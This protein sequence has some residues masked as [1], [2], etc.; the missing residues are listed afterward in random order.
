MVLRC[1]RRL[2]RSIYALDLSGKERLIY[3]SPGGLTIHDLAVP[4]SFCS[5]QTSN[6]SGSP[7]CLPGATHERSLSWFDWCFTGI[8]DDGKTIVFFETGE[9]VGSNYSVFMRGMDGSPAVRLGSGA[10][11]SLSL[12]GK[13]VAALNLASPA[14]I[15]LLPTG[16]GQSRVVTNDSLEHTRARWLP[17]GHGLLF[18]AYDANH[19]PRTYWLDLE[20]GKT[21]AITP[22][23]AG[24]LVVSPDSKFV[25]TTDPE[26][27]RWL[28][29]LEGGDRQ[30]FTATLALK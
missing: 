10:F 24:G 19:P 30:P 17:S 8:S 12:D 20:S 22:E 11:P 16:A 2:A 9:G 15:E 28:Y 5:R 7:L 29:P 14:Q 27:K 18:N 13:W 25:L 1:S 26:R 6:V 23:G 4:A 3:R 21:R